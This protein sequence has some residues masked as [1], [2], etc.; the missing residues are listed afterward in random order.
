MRRKTYIKY[1][2]QEDGTCQITWY[3]GVTLSDIQDK[4]SMGID[5]KLQPCGLQELV[6]VVSTLFKRRCRNHVV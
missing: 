4:D 3:I 2:V 1:Q 5:D 6:K